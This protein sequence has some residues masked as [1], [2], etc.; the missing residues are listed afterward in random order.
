MGTALFIL[1]VLALRCAATRAAAAL[2]VAAVFTRFYMI[3][4]VV[5]LVLFALAFE[6]RQR[7][8]LIAWCVALAAL[9]F[10]AVGLWAGVLQ[11]LD[12]TVFYHVAK[13]HYGRA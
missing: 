5:A 2:C 9:A 3:P 6:P 10:A 11:F 4:G 8:R 13:G 12:D 1:A 7:L